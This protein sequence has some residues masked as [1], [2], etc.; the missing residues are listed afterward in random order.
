MGMP[1]KEFVALMCGVLVIIAFI[2]SI[3]INYLRTKFVRIEDCEKYRGKCNGEICKKIDDLKEE[4]SRYRE[5]REEKDESLY[6]TLADI[7]Q[8]MAVIK[9]HLPPI[10]GNL[11]GWEVLNGGTGR[12]FAG[13]ERRGE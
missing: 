4:L 11:N 1:I 3:V 8:F 7:Q 5:K 12:G 9:S 10:A 6:N 13:T 2:G